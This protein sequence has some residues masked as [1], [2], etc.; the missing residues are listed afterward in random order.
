M[1]VTRIPNRGSPPAILLRES[2]RENGKVKTRTLANLSK[3]PGPVIALVKRALKGEHFATTEDLFEVVASAQHGNVQAVLAAMK[4]LGMERLLGS[5][6][7]RERRLVMGMIAARILEPQSKLAT[8]RWWHTTT[9]PQELEVAD[10]TEDDLYAAMDWL[11]KG[12]ERIEKRLAARH[13]ERGGL[14]LYDLSSSYFEGESCPLAKR[15]YSRDG[16]R[17]T[18]QVNYG[19]LTDQR[20]CP[21]SVSVYAGNT[22]DAKTLLPV[23]G[24]LRGDFGLDSVVMVGDRGMIGQKQIEQLREIENVEWITA[25]KMISIRKLVDGGAL[26]M[27][28]FDERNLFELTHPDY[29]G[30]RLIACRNVELA[31]RRAH[32]REALLAATVRELEQV[33]G[34][35]LRGK[36]QGKDK[37]GVRVGRVINKYKVAKHFELDIED[38]QLEF[39]IRQDLVDAEAALDGLYV[40]R[41]SLP[42]EQLSSD[43]AVRSYKRLTQV[44]RAFRSFKTMDLKVRPIR[45]RLEER[46]RAHI[47]LCMLA[48]YVQWHLQEAWRPLTFS[49]EDQQAKSTR[50][51]IAPASRSAEALR[52]AHERTLDDTTVV[53]GFQS[54][55]ADLSTIVRNTCQRQDAAEGEGTFTMTTTPTDKHRQALQ[56]V[57]DISL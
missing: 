19:L 42:G 53:H 50:D 29:P 2:Y 52:K 9:L 49:D 39:S 20:G 44:E 12:Q 51:P 23:V 32:K 45:H 56:F 10:A 40:I 5:K 34:M 41:T 38:G 35:V 46:V 8:T 16:K 37:I 22:G 13:L 7:S 33:Q 27:G 36:L 30:E 21:V 6:P 43:E 28:L 17:G 54:L 18:L 48:Y 25:L 11:L 15:G 4:R 57:Q 31:K 55:L 26:Q 24:K 14:A 47:F 1:Y 3:L